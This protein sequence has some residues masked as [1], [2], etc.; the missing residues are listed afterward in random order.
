MH[1]STWEY[2]SL[3]EWESIQNP[4]LTYWPLIYVAVNFRSI[5][6]KLIIQNT[7]V[8]SCKI[9]LMWVTKNTSDGISTLVK[10]MMAWY[11]QATS[12][13]M[14]QCWPKTYIAIWHHCATMNKP[15]TE[16]G[17]AMFCPKFDKDWI[18]H[19]IAMDHWDLA[20]SQ[21]AISISNRSATQKRY[22]WGPSQ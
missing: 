19:K 7:L 21:F 18:T 6:F 5:I 10:V 20:R 16:H 13:Y 17:I 22:P 14:N 12:H 8:T 11:G 2:G 3:Q 4:F 15:C 9:A 1:P